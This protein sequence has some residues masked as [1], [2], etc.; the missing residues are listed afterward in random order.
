MNQDVRHYSSGVTGNVTLLTAEGSSR[1]FRYKPLSPGCG[2]PSMAS[3]KSVGT[4][5]VWV[6]CGSEATES[7]KY[8]FVPLNWHGLSGLAEQ[9]ISLRTGRR[10]STARGCQSPLPP[11]GSIGRNWR[12]PNADGPKTFSGSRVAT[13]LSE[14]RRTK[15]ASL[16][17]SIV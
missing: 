10:T 2:T 13:R 17:L 16:K 5:A 4:G 1:N 8:K 14:S 9:R 7:I 12:G 11:W 15:L 6:N 3:R